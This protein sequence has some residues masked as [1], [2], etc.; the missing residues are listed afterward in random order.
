M[1][2]AVT[3]SGPISMTPGVIVVKLNVVGDPVAG[4]GVLLGRRPRGWRS[5]ARPSRSAAWDGAYTGIRRL[6]AVRM[7]PARHRVVAQSRQWS[8]CR[9]LTQTASIS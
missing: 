3:R 4:F 2:A 8:A 6:R 1:C 7:E 9:W 5:S